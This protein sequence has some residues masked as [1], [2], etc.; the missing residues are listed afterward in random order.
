MA[1]LINMSKIQDEKIEKMD[2][3]EKKLW[4]LRHTAEH[5]LHTALQNLYPS[6][7]KAVGSATPDGFY[8]DFDL[9]IKVTES[10]FPKIESEMQRL[11]NADLPMI[12]SSVS[13]EEARRIFKGNP[14]KLDW[15][16]RIEKRGEQVSTYKMGEADLDLCGGPHLKSTGE[17]KAF[18]LLSVAGAYWHGDEKNKMLTRIYGTAFETK[19]E[20]DAYLHNLE[21]AKKRDHRRLGK[22]LELFVF[23]SEVGSGLPLFTEKGAVIRRE[24]ERFIQ[25]EEIQRGYKHVITPDIAK[26]RL[27]EISGHYPY[28]KDTMYPVMQ[29]DEDQLVLR[30]MT[31]PHHFMLYKS[32]PH[33]YRELPLRYAELGKL[34]RYEKSGELTGLVR[35]RGFCLADSHIICTQDQAAD[36]IKKALDLIDFAASTL[37]FTKGTDYK[38]RL[39]MGDTENKEKYFGNPEKW[40]EGEE[41]L[42]KVLVDLNAPFFEAKGEAAFYGPKIDIQMKNIN[43]KEDTAFTVQ[44]DF[45][46]PDR[47][48]LTFIDEE[49]K[50]QRPVVVH[51]S[52]IG[53]I[54]RVMAFLI[55]KFAGSFPVWLSPVQVALIPISDKFV[56]HAKDLD[57]KLKRENIRTEI[58]DQNETMQAKIRD[59]QTQKIPYMLILGQREKESGNVSVRSRDNGDLGSISSEEFI[60]NIV[61]KIKTRA[62][63]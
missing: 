16:D 18:K 47:F 38:Y 30:P 5:V 48:N 20:L 40:S 12:Q 4:A 53:A 52:S 21:E 62:L 50:E 42:R 28:Y 35:V 2:E 31:C 49:G 29:V 57:E 45:C 33:S 10:D 41:I 23:A 13:F 22:E 14:Y 17:I 1:S 43:G 58:F 8:H 59:A 6:M 34:Y 37:G 7:K 27:Y 11:I 44:Y 39:S 25:D 61:E 9:D 56:E 55:E 15:I 36:E 46:M 32:K 60:N 24:L 26:T 63:S 3:K 54:E 51:R 19:E